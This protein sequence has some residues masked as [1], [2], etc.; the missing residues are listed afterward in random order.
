MKI[1]QSPIKLSK[2]SKNEKIITGSDLQGRINNLE[3]RLISI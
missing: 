2:P 3:K 1:A